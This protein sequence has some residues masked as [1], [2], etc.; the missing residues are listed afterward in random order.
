VA[1]TDKSIDSLRK[2]YQNGNL[3]LYLGAGV[4][5]GSGLPTWD[6]LV[7][8]M[9]FSALSK[10]A[11][12]PWHLYPSYL[13]ATA[14]WHLERS[15][16]PLEITARKLRRYYK[17]D[18]DFMMHLWETLYAG[19]LDGFSSGNTAIDPAT[20]CT[21]N[22]T[23]AG[24]TQLCRGSISG[25]QGVRTVI[26]YNYDSLLEIALAD[27]PFQA[28]CKSTPLG[29][30]KLPIYHVH[31]YVPLKVTELTE[32]DI[33]FTEDQYHQSAKDSY[34]WANLVQIQSLSSSTGLMI[35][36]SISDRNMRRLLDAVSQMPVE[37]N[38][39]ALLKE[40]TWEKP[41]QVELQRISEKALSYFFRFEVSGIKTGW[42]T[43]F[44]TKDEEWHEQITSII[45]EVHRVDLDQQSFILE[46]LGVHPI[47]FKEYDE[48]PEILASIRA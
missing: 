33:V 26:T 4:S 28:I 46:Q 29:R 48:I 36:L 35:G 19:F 2:A 32:Q 3:S 14:E 11:Q 10:H 21:G 23:L 24:I 37:T 15:N 5:V 1:G 40:P 20:I 27:H 7:L 38:N 6:K 43:K 30:G 39:F 34:S 9:Y 31:G 22:P 16:E 18:D 44:N 17:D 42:E 25:K 41:D 8:A 47:W 12:R 13:F 45:D